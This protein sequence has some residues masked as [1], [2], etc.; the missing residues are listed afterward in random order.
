MR[1]REGEEEV[2]RRKRERE[3]ER[4]RDGEGEKARQRGYPNFTHMYKSV[5]PSTHTHTVQYTYYL[6]IHLLYYG[7]IVSLIVSKHFLYLLYV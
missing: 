5:C 4:E 3:R 2:G 7:H 1:E 6:L